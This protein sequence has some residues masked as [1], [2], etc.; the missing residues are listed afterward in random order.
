[1][2][3]SELVC[4]TQRHSLPCSSCPPVRIQLLFT[5]VAARLEKQRTCAFQYLQVSSSRTSVEA[6]V[7]A[8]CVRST[9]TLSALSFLRRP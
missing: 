2:C 1:M 3:N 4:S 5:L 8:A 6:R 9:E 7:G